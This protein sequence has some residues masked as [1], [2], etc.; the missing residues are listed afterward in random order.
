MKRDVDLC[1]QLL[2]DLEAHG[3][4][5]AINV[6]RSGTASEVDDRVRYHMRLLIDAG[7]AKEVERTTNGI[8][9]VRLTNAGVE[10]IEL[11]RIDDRWRDAKAVVLEQTGGMS[12]TILR[13]ILSRWA[14]EAVSRGESRRP[15]RIYR[16]YYRRVSPR[17]HYDVPRSQY[18]AYRFDAF[19]DD[20]Y[21]ERD[22]LNLVR[23]TP[24]DYRERNEWR[25]PIYNGDTVHYAMDTLDAGNGV[26]LPDYLV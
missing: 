25:E 18:A 20:L 24:V 16:P 5:C 6:L 17:S 4:D 22:D 11:C 15:R 19:R 13:A 12:L 21:E 10:L 8:A 1:R 14:V 23:S 26:S 9:C 7:F 3:P 2:F